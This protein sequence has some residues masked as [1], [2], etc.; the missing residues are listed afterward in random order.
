MEAIGASAHGP[1]A[2]AQ[3]DAILVVGRPLV[4]EPG[5]FATASGVA[6]PAVTVLA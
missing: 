1:V 2:A 3:A 6:V 4:P 5:S